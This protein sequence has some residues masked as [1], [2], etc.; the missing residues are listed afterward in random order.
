[1]SVL[2]TL[3]AQAAALILLLSSALAW[4]QSG[5]RNV[6][7]IIG[8]GMD[9]QQITLARNYLAGARGKLLLDQLPS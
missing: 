1:M 3:R 5:T 6:I 7:L 4:P 2:K 8:D 9:D